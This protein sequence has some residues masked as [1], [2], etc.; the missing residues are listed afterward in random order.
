MAPA[1]AEAIEINASLRDD[2]PVPP[3]GG[4]L[5]Q[6]ALGCRPDVVAYRFGV[7]YAGAG[8]KL[9]KANRYADAYLLLQPYTFQNNSPNGLKSSY[10]YAVGL[11]VPLPVYNRN[12]G[13]IERVKINID[14]TKI[15]LEALERVVVSEVSQAEEEYRSTRA[16]LERLET[17]VLPLSKKA[18]DDTRRLFA[19]GE[20]KDVTLLLNVQ[21]EYND[22][23]RQYRDTA[24]RHRRSMFGL[25]TAVGSRVLP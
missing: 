16:Y 8:L 6:M 24:I 2:A 7:G 12:Q 14:Q 17:R 4:P 25:N 11:T 13:N 15:Q 18:L 10:S 1:E 22:L 9:Q 20:L 5:T 3:L 21:R 19:A 23:V